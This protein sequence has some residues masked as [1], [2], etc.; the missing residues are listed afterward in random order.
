MAH[1]HEVPDSEES[2]ATLTATEVEEPQESAP[3]V[4]KPKLKM[5][6]GGY[7]TRLPTRHVLT[8]GADQYGIIGCRLVYPKGSPEAAAYKEKMKA[9]RADARAAA[10][11]KNTLPDAP[12]PAQSARYR[13]AGLKKPVSP[14]L[15]TA[16]SRACRAGVGEVPDSEEEEEMSES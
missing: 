3:L 13:A 7:H 10:A 12:E 15:V 1:L 11:Q 16:G 8:V 14:L 9:E 2:D 5:V 6:S 4:L